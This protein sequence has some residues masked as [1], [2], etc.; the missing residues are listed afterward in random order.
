MIAVDMKMISDMEMEPFTA[1]EPYYEPTDY[2]RT[3][4]W[5]FC[6]MNRDDHG[7]LSGLLNYSPDYEHIAD[8]WHR[9]RD[10]IG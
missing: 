1:V 4:N 9:S 10:D 5:F 6:E 2:L 7:F 8:A 3:K